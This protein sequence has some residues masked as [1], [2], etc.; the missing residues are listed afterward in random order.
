MGR[1]DRSMD[2]CARGAA[3]L[4]RG[5]RPAGGAMTKDL[6]GRIALVTGAS[7][8]IGRASALALGRRGARVAVNYRED[9]EGA[10]ATV[11]ALEELRGEGAAVRGDVASA[12][13]VEA[14]FTE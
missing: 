14:M 13:D 7:R 3:L 6:E 5:G 8:G 9:K 10:E 11:R 12:E 2:R 4:R 1:G